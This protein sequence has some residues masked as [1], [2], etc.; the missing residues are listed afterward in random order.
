MSLRSSAGWP[1]Q[2][3]G[4]HIG[5]CSRP[6]IRGPRST[7]PLRRAT[8]YSDHRGESESSTFKP[9]FRRHITF[10]GFHIPMNH[11]FV[12]AAGPTRR[13]AAARRQSHRAEAMPICHLSPQ[14]V[15]GINS[16]VRS[17]A[18]LLWRS[19]ITWRYGM[20]QGERG[21]GLPCGSGCGRLIDR[22]PRRGGLSG[23]FPFQMRVG[24][25]DRPRPSA[26]GL[27]SR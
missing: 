3:L 17:H 9:A 2:L 1:R 18:R 6:P 21:R 20:V 8:R 4:R 24:A 5:R 10:P 19:H 13:Q 15:P 7:E 22:S 26:R 11:A 16:M 14:D 12:M 23:D 27:F 25:R